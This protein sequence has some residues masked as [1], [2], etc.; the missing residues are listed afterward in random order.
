MTYIDV[1]KLL[2]RQV[3]QRFI[4]CA[5]PLFQDF[6][7][8]VGWKVFLVN[9]ERDG[10][11]GVNYKSRSINFYKGPFPAIS[12]EIFDLKLLQIFNFWAKNH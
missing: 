1:C 5:F 6:S 12:L 3:V 2:L 9:V 4:F 11:Y 10:V 7:E 8:F